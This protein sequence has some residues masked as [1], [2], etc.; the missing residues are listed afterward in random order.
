MTGDGVKKARVRLFKEVEIHMFDND[1]APNAVALSDFL[2]PCWLKD[3]KSV[4][5]LATSRSLAGRV[6]DVTTEGV[7]I[8]P[9]VSIG[10]Q[11]PQGEPGE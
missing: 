1:S 6:W 5:T 2:S 10:L 9:A 8:E 7:L 4:S 3:S 11:G